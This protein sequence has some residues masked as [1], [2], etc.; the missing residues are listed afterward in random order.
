[1]NLKIKYINYLK[2]I[3]ILDRILSQLLN[4]Y[5]RGILSAIAW[6]DLV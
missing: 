2:N 3:A 6:Q 4:N 1:M 5:N